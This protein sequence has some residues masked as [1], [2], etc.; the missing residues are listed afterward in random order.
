MRS[1]LLLTSL[2]LTLAATPASA[3]DA[4]ATVFR[5]VQ[6]VPLDESSPSGPQDVV[7]RD[8]RI[9]S[10]APARARLRVKDAVVVEAEGKF[11]LPGL[12]E[13]HAHVPARSAPHLQT[14]LDLFLAHGVTTVRGVLGE[15]G[16]LELRTQLASG[17]MRGPRLHT[18]GPSLNGQSV[19]DAASG[20]A[21]VEAQ[22]RVGY[23][24]LK[25]HPG[26]DLARFDAIADAARRAQLPIAGHVAE[27]V[28]LE[29]SLGG[30]LGTVEHMDD[31]VRALVPEDRPERV[32]SPGFFGV[33]VALAAD[34]ARIPVLVEATRDADAF[35]VPTETLMVSLLGEDSIDALLAREEMI[36]VPAATRAQWRTD[37]EGLRAQVDP[38]KAARFLALRRDLIKALYA[39]DRVL[40]GS[41]A[42]QKFNVPGAA[43]HRELALMVGAGVDARTALRSGTVAP[44]RWLGA[45]DQ[46]GRIATGQDADL[47]LLDADP[48]ADIANTR[49]IT[50]VMVAGR[51]HDRAALDSLLLAARAAAGN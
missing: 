51:W 39:Q 36:Y 28:G 11:L 49:R 8:G 45:G 2:A 50:G 7:V 17:A 32:A 44:A 12:V 1:L 6:I 23:D 3:T 5:R 21:M 15:A 26:L 46:R 10:I 34:A 43:L 30:G 35:V 25:L 14:V 31:Y 13:M 18:A 22:Q 16:Q 42:P 4:S 33:E 40:L 29:H 41:D 20:A 9:E 48:L 24:L 47:I 19:S 37:R 38:A 27:A